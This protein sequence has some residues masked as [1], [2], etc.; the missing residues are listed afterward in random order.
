MIRN[1]AWLAESRDPTDSKSNQ[2][3]HHAVIQFVDSVAPLCELRM[4][5]SLDRRPGMT[6]TRVPKGDIDNPPVGLFLL[7]EEL[8]QVLQMR[9][10]QLGS[11]GEYNHR[12]DRPNESTVRLESLE[13]RSQ[14]LQELPPAEERDDAACELAD[15]A[16]G[17]VD[18]SSIVGGGERRLSS[19]D[20]RRIRDTVASA[21]AS[22]STA[23]RHD[24][25]DAR[26]EDIVSERRYCCTLPPL[27]TGPT[28][29]LRSTSSIIAASLQ[30]F[31]RT[32]YGSPR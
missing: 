27:P 18:R 23:R 28:F 11:A 32:C 14:S 22:S 19:G 30:A 4:Q 2:R 7:V 8:F 1:K 20:S 3:F 26:P 6:D 13:R 25:D 29:S 21:A 24:L 17:F 9:G 12:S 31:A 16:V 15:A 5:Y 10:F